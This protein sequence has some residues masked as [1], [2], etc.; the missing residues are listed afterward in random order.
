MAERN[1]IQKFTDSLRNMWSIPELRKR[2]LFTLGMLAIYRFGGHLPT[3]GVDAHALGRVMAAQNN[4]VFGLYDLFVGGSFARA[5]MFALG[6]M[7]YISA[8]IILQVLG[9]VFPHLEKLQKEGEEGRRK[10]N[11]YTRYLTVLIAV[12]QSFGFALFLESLNQS[13]NIAV[14]PHPGLGFR[15]IYMLTLTTGTIGVM[16]L[17]EQ[18]TERGI[19]NGISLIIMI[20]IIARFPNEILQT[21]VGIQNG[22]IGVNFSARSGPAVGQCPLKSGHKI[23]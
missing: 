16:W 2:L 9:T 3:P 8:S 18:I 5:T 1:V 11:Q 10:I 19:G 7:P 17:G 20:G 22:P 15:L 21:I 6:I 14:V 4:T 12:L 13:T 23:L